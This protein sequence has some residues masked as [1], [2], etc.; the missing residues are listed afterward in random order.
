MISEAHRARYRAH[1]AAR[2]VVHRQS[3]W[4]PRVEQ[5]AEEIRA[6]SIIDYGSGPARGLSMFSRF[7]IRDYDP[8]LP[9][10]DADPGRADLVVCIHA[11][12]HVEPAALASVL[13]DL[14]ARARAA[15]LV[16]VSCEASTK[17]LPDGS[18]WHS[19]V[20]TPDVWRRVLW[21]F[22]EVA[23]IKEPPREFA[24]VWRRHPP[25]IQAAR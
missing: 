10:L 16:V 12:E 18:P 1:Y 19:L 24:A 14:K 7:P 3:V 4:L 21:G 22:V 11:L 15:L 13:L 5:L 20:W 23:P 25:E 8:G 2:P 17:V 6:G 9:G